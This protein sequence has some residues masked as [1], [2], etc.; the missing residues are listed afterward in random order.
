[1]KHIEKFKQLF[2]ASQQ[3]ELVVPLLPP[4]RNEP[5][6]KECETV[7]SSE[8]G[9][10]VEELGE[11]VEEVLEPIALAPDQYIKYMRSQNIQFYIDYR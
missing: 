11:Q 8:V 10:P 9:E 4:P 2:Y 6:S 1:M 7:E 3:E 5:A